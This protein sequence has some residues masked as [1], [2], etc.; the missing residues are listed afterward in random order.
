MTLQNPVLAAAEEKI[1]GQMTPMTKADYEKIIVAGMKV[2]LQG[3]PNSIL[4]KLKDSKNPISDCANGAIN[5]CLL[6][7]KQSRGTMPVKSMVP[8]AMTLMLHA[9]DFA[10]HAGIAKI[11]APELAQ[12]AKILGNAIFQRFKITPAMIHT[13]ATKVHGITQDPAQLAKLKSA[14]GGSQVSPPPAVRPIQP[15]GLIN[16]PH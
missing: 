13:A 11:G 5:L 12:A 4:A 16:G 7:R 14:V 1:E 8:A 6:L 2:A 10:D 15:K 3:G 9:L